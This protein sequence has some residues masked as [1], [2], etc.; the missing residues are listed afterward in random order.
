MPQMALAPFVPDHPRRGGRPRR[1]RGIARPSREPSS[2]CR[3]APAEAGGLP[4]QT[5]GARDDFPSLAAQS[6]K[7][8]RT[9]LRRTNSSRENTTTSTPTPIC[10]IARRSR[11]YLVASSGTSSSMTSRSRSEP[12]SSIAP[13]VRPKQDHLRR[14]AGCNVLR[15][16]QR[17]RLLRVRACA[18]SIHKRL[19]YRLSVA[20]HHVVDAEAA[21]RRAG[22][23]RRV[24]LP[25][26]SIRS[27]AQEASAMALRIFGRGPSRPV[28]PA[29]TSSALPP[30]S[31]RDHR[32]AAGHGL[33]DGVGDAFGLRR[34]RK[35]V[36]RAH[37]LGHVAARAREPGDVADAGGGDLGLDLGALRAVAG[38]DADAAGRLPRPA[39]ARWPWRAPG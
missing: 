17:P 38:D 26:R 27:V 23:R 31:V 14:A 11:T 13:R 24:T 25:Q 10:L 32:Q 1:V 19:W 29:A 4:L 3:A 12:S 16:A 36:E 18:Y 2:R 6:Y 35:D 33:E 21:L 15:A 30:T 8:P 9:W 34:Q 37:D 22:G 5:A 20:L 39:R 7:V 28:S